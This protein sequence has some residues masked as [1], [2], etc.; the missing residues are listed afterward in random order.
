MMLYHKPEEFAVEL[1]ENNR[2]AFVLKSGNQN[3]I[4]I[5]AGKSLKI[6]TSPDGE[7][8]LDVECPEGKAWV[9]RVI[10]EINETDA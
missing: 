3:G 6:E 10:V 8:I 4:T 9:A 7:D 2:P 1:I 5:S